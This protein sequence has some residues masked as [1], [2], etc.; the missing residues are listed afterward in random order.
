MKSVLTSY[1]LKISFIVVMGFCYSS[2]VAQV[3]LPDFLCVKGDTLFWDIMTESCGDFLG[4]DV[5]FSTDRDGPYDLIA[6]ITDL[7]EEFFEHG[8]MS[9]LRYYYLIS[10]FDCPDGIS[11]PSDT[12]DNRPP[13]TVRLN[14]ITVE[15]GGVR[16]D[17]Q[18]SISPQTRAYIIYRVSSQGT[19]PIDT[20][21]GGGNSFFDPMSNPNEKVEFYYVLAMDACETRGPFDVAHNTIFLQASHDECTR[22]ATLTWNDYNFWPDGYGTWEIYVS[23]NGGPEYLAGTTEADITEFIFP[24]LRNGVNYC[25]RVEVSETEIETNRSASNQVCFNA[26]VIEPVRYLCW[27]DV[28]SQPNGSVLLQYQISIGA[29]LEYLRIKRGTTPGN[30]QNVI[31]DLDDPIFI[32]ELNSFL[33]ET[34]N[35]ALNQYYYQIET[36]DGCGD[37]FLSPVIGN[38]PIR[39][40]LLPGRQN[41]I[42]WQEFFMEG[43]VVENYRI[44]QIQNGGQVLLSDEEAGTTEYL[45]VIDGPAVGNTI[46]CYRVIVTTDAECQGFEYSSTHTSPVICIEQNSTIL[47]PNALVVGGV[48]NLFKPVILYPESI[49]SYQIRIFD[50]FGGVVFE[51]TDTQQGWD[52]SKGGKA[53]P[54]GV[55]HFYIRAT[56]TNG[57]V[58]EETGPITLIR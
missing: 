27:R 47:A 45:D 44:L 20:L 48:N 58:I 50:R 55:Y 53:L 25:F 28:N 57:R 19:I 1:W 49:N 7:D 21:F 40:E 51:S 2:S 3:Q 12:L 41:L 52:G 14:F 24:D 10:R 35:V 37:I 54:L 39:G 29:D 22:A 56:Q 4:L 34:N 42:S 9:P 17:W 8:D 13:A 31:I 30:I 18:P 43:A 38:F 32:T 5:Y 36:R 6:T 46:F 15:S 33:D 11:M 16:L 26:N 23:E